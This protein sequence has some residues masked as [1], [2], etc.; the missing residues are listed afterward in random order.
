MTTSGTG[1]EMPDPEAGYVPEPTSPQPDDELGKA[2]LTVEGDLDGT[3][4][5]T[6]EVDDDGEES[7]DDKA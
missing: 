3:A 4:G 6:D 5:P 2:S 7:E 1:R